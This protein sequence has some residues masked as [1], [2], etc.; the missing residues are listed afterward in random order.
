M[1]PGPYQEGPID[2]AADAHCREGTRTL[3]EILRTSLAVYAEGHRPA[4]ESRDSRSDFSEVTG[5]EVATALAR[6]MN[7]SR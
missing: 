1:K 6:A 5:R 4:T 3:R 7:L 2:G